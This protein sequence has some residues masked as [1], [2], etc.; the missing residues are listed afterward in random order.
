MSDLT[1]DLNGYFGVSG[2]PLSTINPCSKIGADGG[3]RT[4]KT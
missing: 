2:L 4:P 1:G 3:T